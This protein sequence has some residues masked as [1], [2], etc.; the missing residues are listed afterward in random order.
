MKKWHLLSEECVSFKTFCIAKSC[1]SVC[2]FFFFFFMFIQQEVFLFLHLVAFLGNT[3]T[4]EMAVIDDRWQIEEKRWIFIIIPQITDCCDW[5][6]SF[7]GRYIKK[8]WHVLN[9]C[10]CFHFFFFFFWIKI[11][12]YFCGVILHFMPAVW[13]KVEKGTTTTEWKGHGSSCLWF[14]VFFGALR[15]QCGASTAIARAVQ[16]GARSCLSPLPKKKNLGHRYLAKGV[17]S[18]VQHATLLHLS[19]AWPGDDRKRV[20][21]L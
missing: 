3:S 16:I 6:I 10:C 11:I 21:L 15:Q 2:L 19:P 9:V 1:S 7:G 13:R 14:L 20:G 8:K 5:S 4:G 12:V 18:V 17:T